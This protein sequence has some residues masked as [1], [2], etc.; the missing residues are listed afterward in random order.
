MNDSPSRDF[1]RLAVTL[2]VLWLA[3][4]SLFKL[5]AGTPA[6]LPR[7]VLDAVPSDSWGLVL[8]VAIAA[9]LSI[10]VAGLLRPRLAWPAVVAIY[11]LFE[12]VL[13]IGAAAGDASCGCFGASITISPTL[14]MWIDGVLLLGVLAARPWKSRAKAVGSIWLIPLVVVGCTALPFWY[15][16]EEEEERWV[17]L[18]IMSWEGQYVYDTELATLLPEEIEILPID[19]QYIFYRS[20]CDHCALHLEELA[21]TDDG[22]QPIVLIRIH[23]D[24]DNDENNLVLTVPIGGHVTKVSL[25]EGP[26]YLLE[27]A[28][29]F[30]LVGGRVT[31]PREGIGLDEGEE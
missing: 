24:G 27:T 19:G 31:E 25:P 26:Q 20:T 30:K 14:M 29:D 1:T 21:L 11:L 17:T 18:D 5:L 12:V 15:I 13:A 16:G 7:T 4:G 10:T 8:K 3:A 23:E 6:D 9:E 28:A 22:S 2:A